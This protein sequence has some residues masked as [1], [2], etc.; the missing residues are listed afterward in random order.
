[1]NAF[2]APVVGKVIKARGTLSAL[3]P[4]EKEAKDLKMG[5]P[6][7][8]DTS[9][10]SGDGSF[11]QIEMND[12]SR[13]VLGPKSKM[14]V[15]F[16]K[17]NEGGV[18]SLLKG[19]VRSEVKKEDDGKTKMLVRTRSAAMGVRG[20]D[21]QAT[22]NPES[23]T[24]SLLTYTGQVAMVKVDKKDSK[25]LIDLTTNKNKSKENLESVFKDKKPVLVEKGS[26][27]AVT[28]KLKKA[29][30]PVNLNPV[31]FSVLK[32]NK[33]FVT[34]KSDIPQEKIEKEVESIK[35][36]LKER[37]VENKETA[38]AEFDPKTGQYKPKDGGLVDLDTGLYIPPAK[39]SK[40]DKKLNIYVE[41]NVEQKISDNGD[42]VPPKGVVLDAKKGFVAEN[43]DEEKVAELNK[44][45][46]AQVIEPKKKPTIDDLES[47]DDAYDKYFN[48]ED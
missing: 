21:F 6:V 46:A 17:K 39:D 3:F 32:L 28:E 31:Q 23:N 44:E 15:N 27:S 1:M 24:T 12:G 8:E 5:M 26:Y 41:E 30:K 13:L 14:V 29:T 9:I 25:K 11:A 22:F 19:K 2:A 20:T 37:A 45:I 10:L 4:G 38:N 47:D 36:V 43:G 16:M 34:K 48:Y 18:I 40:F 42:F 35:K 7:M 33:D